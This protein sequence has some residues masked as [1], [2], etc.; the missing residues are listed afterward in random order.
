MDSAELLEFLTFYQDLENGL[1]Y[2]FNADWL[3]HAN[4]NPAKEIRFTSSAS[5][6]AVGNL[7][8]NV[9][10]NCEVITWGT[11]TDCPLIPSPTLYPREGQLPC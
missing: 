3:I 7:M 8:Y 11:D 4:N 2:K 10:I 9:S 1:D 6:K 5:I